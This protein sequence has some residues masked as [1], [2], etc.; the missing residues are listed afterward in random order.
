[1]AIAFLVQPR[2]FITFVKLIY[3]STSYKQRRISSGKNKHCKLDRWQVM[4]L[5]RANLIFKDYSY[6]RKITYKF[7]ITCTSE[8]LFS[9]TYSKLFKA[10]SCI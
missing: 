3:S 8:Q 6:N 5:A 2:I 7:L 4:L 1:M 10:D 9:P